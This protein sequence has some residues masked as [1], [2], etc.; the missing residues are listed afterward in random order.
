MQAYENVSSELLLTEYTANQQA[1]KELEATLK[2]QRDEIE[3]RVRNGLEV[4][5]SKVHAELQQAEY[6]TYSVKNAM[7]AIRK[8]RL[9]PASLLKVINSAVKGLPEEIQNS[10]NYVTEVKDKLVVKANK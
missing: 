10:I 1:K 9:D 5:N 3:S 8:H 2:A 4:K 6:R 7:T